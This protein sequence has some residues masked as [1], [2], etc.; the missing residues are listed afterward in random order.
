MGRAA[1]AV[2][3]KP[4]LQNK[5]YV[6]F[7][8]SDGDNLQFVE[9][10]MRKLMDDLGIRCYSTHNDEDFFSAQKIDRARDL[11]VDENLRFFARVLGVGDDRVAECAGCG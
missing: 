7:I 9:H 6:A 8:L 10:L 11:T 1:A 5:I 4:P 3:P 2:P